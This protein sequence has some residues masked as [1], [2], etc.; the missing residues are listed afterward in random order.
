MRWQAAAPISNGAAATP[1][2][3]AVAAPF[4]PM[5]VGGEVAG[6]GR[7]VILIP[8][9]SCPGSVWAETVAHLSGMQTH[10]LTLSGF[11]R[12]AIDQPLIATVRAELAT[13]I[14]DRHLDHPIVIGHSMGGFLAYAL[15]EAEPDLVGPVVIVD[16]GLALGSENGAVAMATQMRDSWL[17]MPHDKFAQTT[18]AFFSNMITDAGKLAWVSDEVV[19]SDQRTMAN[20]FFDLMTTDLRPD[21][22]KIHAPL[23]LVAA[24]EFR[25]RPSSRRR[26]GDR[27]EPERCDSPHS[28]LRDARRSRELVPRD[29][30]LP[31]RA[32]GR[33]L[34]TP[35][36][37]LIG[38]LRQPAQVAAR[39]GRAAR[40]PYPGRTCS[41]A[42]PPSSPRSASSAP[43]CRRLP[44][45]TSFQVTTTT[46]RLMVW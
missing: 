14:R 1:V 9:L 32:S 11:A 33:A 6:S 12:R 35:R 41:S 23:L 5:S 18:R 3:V 37:A 21:A 26:P 10:V 46:R 7:P 31:G 40:E 4:E 28:P 42:P 39:P 22:G 44:V 16:A 25:I 45:T 38:E 13:Y 15:A 8:G 34:T 17:A 20:A 27:R 19:R 29:R 24:D 43:A 30:R 2:A 36:Q